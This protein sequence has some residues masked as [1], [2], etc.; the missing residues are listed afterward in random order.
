MPEEKRLGDQARDIAGKVITFIDEM[1]EELLHVQKA[2]LRKGHVELL[3]R[4]VMVRQHEALRAIGELVL[5]HRGDIAS[6]LLRPAVEEL[7]AI[8]FLKSLDANDAE[9]LALTLSMREVSRSLE[10]QNNHTDEEVMKDLG[11]DDYYK[12]H[13]RF[14]PVIDA[15]LKV[16]KKK[17]GWDGGA[18]PSV[19]FMARRTN[20]KDIYDFLYFAT[21]RTV[22]FNAMELMRRG[23]GSGT[24]VTLSSTHYE[25]YWALFSL[26]WGWRIYIDIWTENGDLMKPDELPEARAEEI[27]RLSKEI[28]DIGQIPIVTQAELFWESKQDSD[29]KH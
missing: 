2:D 19:A 27:M 28:S 7:I 21:S 17:I 18:T 20:S 15:R 14:R 11:L 29:V 5:Q 24:T 26:S 6:A 1:N 10:A 3:R 23:W 13:Q 4:A 25:P 22:H 12:R 16:L 9:R 8:R